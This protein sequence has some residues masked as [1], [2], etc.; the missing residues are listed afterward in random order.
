MLKKNLVL[1]IL[2]YVCCDIY[3]GFA[4]EYFEKQ[5]FNDSITL[6]AG[7]YSSLGCSFY[8]K[9]YDT[10]DFLEINIYRQ[11]SG[12][13]KMLV[14]CDYKKIG[15]YNPYDDDAHTLIQMVYDAGLINKASKFSKFGEMCWYMSEY[16]NDNFAK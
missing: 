12:L 6:S 3:N 16:L 4:Y 5:V 14:T 13:K 7:G 10:G 9:N 15:Y 11:D 1:V 8:I 2:I